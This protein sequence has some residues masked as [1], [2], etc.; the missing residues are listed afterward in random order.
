MLSEETAVGDYPVESVLMLGQIAREAERAL[1]SRTAPADRDVAALMAEAACRLA[2]ELDAAAIVVPSRTG[3]TAR[4]VARHRPRVPIVA[5]V[6]DERIRRQLSLVWGVT[7]I[8]L[9]PEPK[10]DF[11]LAAFRAPLLQ[12]GLVATGSL[13]V[14]TA[15]W[16]PSEPAHTNLVHATRL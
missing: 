3:F 9:P 16:P 13:I 2:A 11:V 5:L 1:A 15:A 12:T 7:A 8:T 14:L 10:G 6:P 4:Q